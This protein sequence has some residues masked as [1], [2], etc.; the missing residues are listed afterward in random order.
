MKQKSFYPLFLAG[1]IA[2]TSG[3]LVSCTENEPE[4][5][6]TQRIVINCTDSMTDASI[7]SGSRTRSVP[8]STKIGSSVLTS[9]SGKKL[10]LSCTETVWP[11]DKTVKTRG[12]KVTTAGIS[13]LGVSASVYPAANT[14][15]SAGCGSYFYKES[16]SSGTP[17]SYYWPTAGY[18]LPV[19]PVRRHMPIPCR[20]L[21]PISRIS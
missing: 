20:P 12:T 6:T 21:S 18:R 13:N 4:M 11:S 2:L 3:V 7:S 10:Y 15:T 5:F 1:L 17:M 14:Y 8:E 9:K 19:L 16:V